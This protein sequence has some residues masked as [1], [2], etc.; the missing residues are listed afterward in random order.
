MRASLS[1]SSSSPSLSSSAPFT[2][3]RVSISTAQ[4]KRRPNARARYIRAFFDPRGNRRARS[5]TVRNRTIDHPSIGIVSAAFAGILSSG[6]FVRF[7]DRSDSVE[8]I[9]KIEQPY[10]INANRDL[11]LMYIPL[12]FPIVPVMNEIKGRSYRG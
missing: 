7:S 12:W 10:N 8:S 9:L 6:Y 3:C 1:S 11:I 2:H 5:I 4:R